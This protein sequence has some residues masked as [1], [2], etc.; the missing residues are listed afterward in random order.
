MIVPTLTPTLTMASE[1]RRRSSVLWFLDILG[2]K[3][4]RESS[5]AAK[6]SSLNSG[7]AVVRSWDG[8]SMWEKPHV[9]KGAMTWLASRPRVVYKSAAP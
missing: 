7:L 3:Q 1:V 2:N 5:H 9:S 6:F 8:Q 4:C